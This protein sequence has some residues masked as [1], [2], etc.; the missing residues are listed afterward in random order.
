MEIYVSLFGKKKNVFGWLKLL[1]Q[2]KIPFRYK[3]ERLGDF[4]CINILVS[5]PKRK[6]KRFSKSKG[7][8]IYIV[9]SKPIP[10]REKLIRAFNLLDLPYIHFWYYQTIQPSVFLFRIDVDYVYQK[11]LESIFEITKKFGIKGTYFLNISG[12]EEFDEEIGHLKLK[13]PTTPERKE[14][15]GKILDEG[16]EIANHGYWHYVFRNFKENDRNI[17]KCRLYL[18]ELFSITDEGFAA[19]GGVQNKCLYQVLNKNKFLYSCNT[20]SQKGELPFYHSYDGLENKVLEIPFYNIS[21]AKFESVFK[22]FDNPRIK[23]T[24]VKLKQNYLKYIDIQIKDNKPIAIM[25]HPHLVGKRARIFLSPIFKKIFRL[26]IPNCTLKTFAKWWKKR[27]KFKLK[28]F[29]QNN[30][31]MIYSNNTALIEIIFPGKRKILKVNKGKSKINLINYFY[32]K[33]S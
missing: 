27:E 29:K 6:I 8:K 5:F 15:I 13:K 4:S 28:Y 24:I 19:P 31:I 2:E 23:E 10:S 30:R 3:G 22:E 18:K 32:E 7:N 9:E 33:E 11:G 20:F 21:D 1:E 17:K 12:E 14:L 16:N 25:V 26:G